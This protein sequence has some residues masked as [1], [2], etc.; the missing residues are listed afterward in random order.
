MAVS[1]V[2]LPMGGDAEVN[3]KLVLLKLID[4]LDELV[5][6]EEALVHRKLA[7]CGPCNPGPVRV[8]LEAMP[9]DVV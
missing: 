1:L 6:V 2:N 5:F 7:V 8:L 4:S 3:D 9:I